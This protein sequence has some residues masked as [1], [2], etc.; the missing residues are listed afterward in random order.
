[1]IR[2]L[3]SHFGATAIYVDYT[4]SPEAHTRRHAATCW[5]SEHNKGIEM[6]GTRLAIQ[7]AGKAL[8]RDLK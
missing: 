1:M 5:V 3:V 7:Q 8:K 6:D 4:P 2:Q